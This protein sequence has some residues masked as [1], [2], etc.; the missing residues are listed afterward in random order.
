MDEKEWREL[1]WSEIKELRVE[2]KEIRNENKAILETMT[3]LKLKIG[4]IASVIGGATSLTIAYI[5][6]KLLGV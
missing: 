1:F 4:V 3:T 2:V 6:T 5:K